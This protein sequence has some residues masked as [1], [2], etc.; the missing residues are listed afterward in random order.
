MSAKMKKA[1]GWVQRMKQMQET[2]IPFHKNLF[3]DTCLKYQSLNSWEFH[4]QHLLKYIS[5]VEFSNDGSLLATGAA[6]NRVAVWPIGEVLG[7]KT[8]K[9]ILMLD[10]ELYYGGYVS[11]VAFSQEKLVFPDVR[12]DAFSAAVPQKQVSLFTTWKG[13]F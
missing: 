13:T 3:V 7:G 9:P 5:A 10:N 4:S 11:T 12:R 2:G 6:S 8:P 1:T